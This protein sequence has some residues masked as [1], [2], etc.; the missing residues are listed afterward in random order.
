MRF[1][2]H[3]PRKITETNA[4]IVLNGNIAIWNASPGAFFTEKSPIEMKV[5]Y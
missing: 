5:T 4:D 2:L 1:V 3:A